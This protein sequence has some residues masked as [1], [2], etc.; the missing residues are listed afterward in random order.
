MFLNLSH[1][2]LDVYKYS[3]NLTLEVYRFTK[4]LP[5]TEKFN[6]ISQLRRAAL[7]VHLN[8]AESCSRKSLTERKR[9]YEIARGSV[10]EL[11][12]ALD[13]TVGLDYT[14][15]SQLNDL[16]SIIVLSKY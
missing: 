12:A 9:Y 7:S 13:I 6:L 14:T 11:D 8:I 5:D 3:Y 10:I 1:T 2:N 16:G 4:K 15:K